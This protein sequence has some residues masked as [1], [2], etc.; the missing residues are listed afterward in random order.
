MR[1]SFKIQYDDIIFW[2]FFFH[3][4]FKYI[5]LSF[6]SDSSSV[7]PE[8]HLNDGK[9]NSFSKNLTLSR[10]LQDDGELEHNSLPGLP[11]RFSDPSEN[12][13]GI[14]IS[15]AQSSRALSTGWN[16]ALAAAAGAAALQK[17]K[18]NMRKQQ[19]LNVRPARALFC[20]ALRNP[21]RKLC[22]RVAEWKY[23]FICCLLTELLNYFLCAL[24]GTFLRMK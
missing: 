15:S 24:A 9:E 4:H 8:C 3:T 11:L 19:S 18:A 23:P 7:W 17:K 16:T 20:L 14:P 13:S 12:L 22:I 2:V 5:T 6:F 10:G 21:I 1:K